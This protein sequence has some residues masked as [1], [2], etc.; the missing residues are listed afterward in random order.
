MGL[1]A[2]AVWSGSQDLAQS[3]YVI[4]PAKENTI[5]HLHFIHWK[6][7]TPNAFKH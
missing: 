1:Y 5:L 6:H 7:R 4:S 3:S 2:E